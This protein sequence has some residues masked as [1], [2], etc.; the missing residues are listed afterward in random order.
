MRTLWDWLWPIA[1]GCVV[2]YGIMRWVISFAI[3]PTSSMAPTIPNPCYILVD[4]I[5]TEFFP[6]HEGE[7]VLFHYPDDTKEIFVKRL[8]GMPGDTV[9]IHGGHVYINGKLLPE[10]Y[11]KDTNQP[12]WLPYKQG[13]WGPYKVPKGEY[14]MLGDNRPVSDDSRF[15]QPYKYVPRSYIVGRADYVIWP[16]GRAKPI[17]Q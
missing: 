15:W 1:L 4:H 16:L 14:F 2:A 5:A 17:P 13:T 6:L 9:Y 8:I 10:P 12:D 7:V 11:L 3:V